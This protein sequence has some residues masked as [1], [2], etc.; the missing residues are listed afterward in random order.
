MNGQRIEPGRMRAC[1]GIQKMRRRRSQKV[2]RGETSGRQGKDFCALEERHKEGAASSTR[3][4]C[5]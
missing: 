2:A 5:G 3:G 4:H 1:L